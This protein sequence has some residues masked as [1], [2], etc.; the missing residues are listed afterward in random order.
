M[1]TLTRKQYPSPYGYTFQELLKSIVNNE[2]TLNHPFVAPKLPKFKVEK[3]KLEITAGVMNFAK[4]L[5]P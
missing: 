3:K 1:K 2:D 4:L 5:L